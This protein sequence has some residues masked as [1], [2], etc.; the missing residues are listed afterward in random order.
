MSGHMNNA[1]PLPVPVYE[2]SVWFANNDLTGP[3]VIVARKKVVEL[4]GVFR[5]DAARAAANADT[6]AYSVL[7][8]LPVAEGTEAGLFFGIS[9]LEPGLVADEYFMTRGHF[10][11]KSDRAEYYWG[12]S[13]SGL[14]LL[15]DRDRNARVEAVKPGSLHFI[16]GHTAH[17]LVNIGTTQ[18]RVGA[19]W[20]SDA[21]H[22]YDALMPGGFG[23]RVFCR[24]G[25]PVIE[26][27]A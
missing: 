15:M 23:V 18:L 12:L 25:K 5:D 24:D 1:A 3:T 14:L 27:S 9:I 13:G 7:A 19:C 17:R 6:L 20:P 10:H 11:A 21:G 2:P 16:P 22:D 4:K 26:R 8:H